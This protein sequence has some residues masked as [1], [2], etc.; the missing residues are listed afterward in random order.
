[1]TS[2]PA[3]IAVSVATKGEAA[4]DQLRRLILVGELAPG[5]TI[6]QERLAMDLGLSTTPLREALRRLEGEGLVSLDRNRRVSVAPL[7]RVEL[8]ELYALREVLDPMA[9]GLAAAALADDE[10]DQVSQLA[11]RPIPAKADRA[12]WLGENRRFHRAIYSRCGNTVLA[13]LLDSLWDRGDRYRI[14]L[15]QDTGDLQESRLEHIAISKALAER[16]A[17]KATSLMRAHV[18]RSQALIAERAEIF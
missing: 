6:Q 15:M 9:A 4:Y 18:A 1:M 5:V 3:G 8:S 10:V 14:H 13:D 17:R 16:S 7:T 2:S 11:S 12:E